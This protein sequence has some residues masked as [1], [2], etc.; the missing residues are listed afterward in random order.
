MGVHETAEHWCRLGRAVRDRDR[1]P[2][3]RLAGMAMAHSSEGFLA[4][5]NPLEAPVVSTFTE[6]VCPCDPDR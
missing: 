6:I 5:D 4:F 2:L 3:D 1:A